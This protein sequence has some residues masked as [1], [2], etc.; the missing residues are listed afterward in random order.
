[1]ISDK[2]LNNNVCYF[3]GGIVRF[4]YR[5]H[6]SILNEITLTKHFFSYTMG[7]YQQLLY[8]IIIQHNIITTYILNEHTIQK[9]TGYAHIIIII[10]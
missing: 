8:F 7:Y 2:G 10:L 6:C 3:F 9:K 1:M 4:I 5:E